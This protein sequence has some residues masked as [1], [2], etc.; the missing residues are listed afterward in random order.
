MIQHEF[1]ENA[2][3]DV[4][5]RSSALLQ[6]VPQTNLSGQST[7]GDS[8]PSLLSI[9]QSQRE[10]FR[11]RVQELENENSSQAANIGSLTQEIENLRLDNVKL[12]EKIKFLQNYRP[13]SANSGYQVRVTETQEFE[14]VNLK[15]LT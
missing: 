7:N 4:T 15:K 14:L 6:E 9:V 13:N 2:L 1:L 12:Y 11:L 10:R 3:K 5:Q 8:D